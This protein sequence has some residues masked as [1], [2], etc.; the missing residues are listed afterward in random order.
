[1]IPSETPDCGSLADPE[2]GRVNTSTGTTVGSEAVYSCN[3]GYD[4]VGPEMRACTSNGTWSDTEPV[5]VC[6][7]ALPSFEKHQPL[8]FFTLLSV[9]V[10]DCGILID[11]ENG[12]VDLSQDTTFE[13]IA[14]YSCDL[15]YNLNGPGT[16]TC[17]SDG[18][19]SNTAPTC[20][21]K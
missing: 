6:K 10:K 18:E 1:M 19:W 8:L 4:L 11:P 2:N 3:G 5:C 16:R 20:M 21:C 7:L 15:G 13:S 9:V 12:A 17:Q 14:I